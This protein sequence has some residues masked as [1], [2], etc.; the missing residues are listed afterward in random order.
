MARRMPLT[1]MANEM[2]PRPWK[3]GL[4]FEQFG[5]C[6]DAVVEQL[7]LESQSAGARCSPHRSSCKS[8][9]RLP[10]RIPS[11]TAKRCLGGKPG[12]AGPAVRRTSGGNRRFWVRASG[13]PWGVTSSLVQMSS[14]FLRSLRSGARSPGQWR[15][16]G[17]GVRSSPSFVRR[18]SR[19]GSRIR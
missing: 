15:T 10:G 19:A 3:G 18:R 2:A 1:F 17:W 16:A 4:P 14:T 9:G 13:C 7:F 6:A 12:R 11:A 5:Y 8:A